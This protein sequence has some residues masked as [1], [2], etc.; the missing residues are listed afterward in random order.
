MRHTNEPTTRLHYD[1]RLLLDPARQHINVSGSLVFHA[2]KGGAHRASFYL[3]RELIVKTLEGRGV[4]GYHFEVLPNEDPLPFFPEAGTLDVYFDPPLAANR[5]A[6]IEFEYEGRIT[7]WPDYSCNLLTPEW[8][9]MGLYLPWFPLLFD[10]TASLTFTLQVT[11]PPGYTVASYGSPERQGDTWYINWPHPTNDIV[12]AAGHNLRTQVFESESNR[13]LLHSVSLGDEAAAL[14]GEDMLWTLERFSGWFGPIRPAEFG[15]IQSPRPMGGGYSRRGLVVM[16]DLNEHEF[17]DQREGYLRYLAHEAAHAWWYSA[18]VAS[19][20]DWLNEGFAEY[21][22]LMAIRERLG[23]DTFERYLERKRKQVG[24]TLPDGSVPLWG[25]NR[26]DTATAAKQELV[27][28]QLYSK[29]PLLLHELSNRIG[30]RRFLDLCR[31][32]QWAGVNTTGHFLDLLEEVE[33]AEVRA[34]MEESLKS[35]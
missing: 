9:E 4:S 3:H 16:S 23:Q 13:V 27:E 1:L 2:T 24:E 10:N 29:G 15:L 20:E 34:W 33:G 21:S 31:G 22:A 19:W 25:F 35:L 6:L 18:P 28:T 14:L 11:C 8:V 7:R 30:V 5:S 32:M 17:L 12:L 26:T